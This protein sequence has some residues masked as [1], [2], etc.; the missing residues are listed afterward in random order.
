M[1][2]APQ[3]KQKTLIRTD[4]REAVYNVAPQLSRLQAEVILNDFFEEIVEA[5]VRGEDVKLHGFGAYKLLHKKARPGR[6]PRTKQPA[7]I[8]ARRVVSF[9]ASSILIDRI[10]GDEV[11]EEIDK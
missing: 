8:T 11:A 9:Q 7:I 2:D 5:L 10:N 4:L 1:K 3:S 6:N